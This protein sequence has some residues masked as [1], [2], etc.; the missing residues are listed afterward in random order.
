MIGDNAKRLLIANTVKK[1]FN[2]RAV[3]NLDLE[4]LKK[5]DSPLTN[6]DIVITDGMYYLRYEPVTKGNNY[7]DKPFLI[8][9]DLFTM[10]KIRIASY[11]ALV[12]L[13]QKS[14]EVKFLLKFS[15]VSPKAFGLAKNYP[16]LQIPIMI[17]YIK[18][19]EYIKEKYPD[20]NYK[21]IFREVLEDDN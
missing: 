3:I 1:R 16:G 8:K 10:D 21:Q 11:A 4:P 13:S 19:E 5:G 14:K 9:S 18:Y 6:D 20:I 12:K 17:D 7:V 15:N 2:S